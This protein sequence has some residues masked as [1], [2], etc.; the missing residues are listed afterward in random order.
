MN[1]ASAQLVHALISNTEAEDR[2][3]SLFTCSGSTITHMAGYDH[4]RFSWKN[5]SEAEPLRPGQ[6]YS[7]S[8]TLCMSHSWREYILH[9]CPKHAYCILAFRE[10]V[11]F[12]LQ[13]ANWSTITVH[14]TNNV[15]HTYKLFIKLNW[16]IAADSRD[17]C[18][19][20]RLWCNLDGNVCFYC[21]SHLSKVAK[22]CQ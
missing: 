14:A 17:V 1:R 16:T 12:L 10:R 11:T 4:T 9:Q 13:C 5:R 19:G 21:P 7:Q 18:S 6:C 8:K 20:R 3:Q 2:F 15:Y 22:S